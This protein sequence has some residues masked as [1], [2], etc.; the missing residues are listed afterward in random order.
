LAVAV[1]LAMVGLTGVVPSV[2]EAAQPESCSMRLAPTVDLMERGTLEL[3]GVVT[4]LNTLNGLLSKL[5]RE[6]QKPENVL[7]CPDTLADR[8]ADVD[9][10]IR[11]IRLEPLQRTRADLRVCSDHFQ[12]RIER[13]IEAA[14]ARGDVDAVLQLSRIRPRVTALVSGAVR[15][16]QRHQS[17]TFKV[18]RMARELESLM[19]VCAAGGLADTY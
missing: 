4:Q 8:I 7:S 18:E 11:S 2:A 19:A 14:E 12:R 1:A 9:A 10:A 5:R 15:F 17:L 16:A 3:E 6:T 13:D